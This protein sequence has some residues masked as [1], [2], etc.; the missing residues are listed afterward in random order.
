[1]NV[2]A[3]MS[4]VSPPSR[5]QG[6]TGGAGDE[7]QGATWDTRKFREECDMFKAK[8]SDQ[9]FNPGNGPWT[10]DFSVAGLMDVF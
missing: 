8:L 1:M 7:K 4:D 6:E 9:K 5:R 3:T 10:L 2:D